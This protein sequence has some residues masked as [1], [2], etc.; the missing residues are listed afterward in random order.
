MT[1]H[2]PRLSPF[3]LANLRLDQPRSP[4]QVSALATLEG[5]ALLDDAG[6]L[7]MPQ[8]KER[9]ARRIGRVPQLRKRLY[10]PGWLRGRLLWIDDASFDIDRHIFEA[11]VASPGDEFQLLERRAD[12]QRARRSPPR[13]FAEEVIPPASRTG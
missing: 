8:I 1:Q 6:H 7:Q 2:F 11:A 5:A 12:Q 9:L 3:D 4:F 10:Y 13:F